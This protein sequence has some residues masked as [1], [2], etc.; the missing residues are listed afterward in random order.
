MP[1]PLFLD[2]ISAVDIDVQ[3]MANG[4]SFPSANTETTVPLSAG[5]IFAF[6]CVSPGHIMF[7]PDKTNFIAP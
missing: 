1:M 3:P 4:C 7:A 6:G 5:V 2:A